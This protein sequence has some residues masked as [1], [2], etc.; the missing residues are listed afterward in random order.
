M[1]QTPEERFEEMVEKF[2]MPRR[3][4]ACGTPATVAA[5]N[6]ISMAGEWVTFSYCDVCLPRLGDGTIGFVRRSDGI[7]VEQVIDA[8]W[9]EDAGGWGEYPWLEEGDFPGRGRQVRV[10]RCAGGAGRAG[11]AA[12]A[13]GGAVRVVWR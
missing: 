11:V 8:R 7:A 12:G 2:L 4:C 6:W 10:V 13:V 9:S 3:P 1:L 5:G